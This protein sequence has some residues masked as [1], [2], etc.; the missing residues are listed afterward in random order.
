MHDKDLWDVWRL[1]HR[2]GVPAEAPLEEEQAR[3]SVRLSVPECA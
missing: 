3:L 1:L 2:G